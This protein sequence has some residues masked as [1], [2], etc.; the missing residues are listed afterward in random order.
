[1]GDGSFVLTSN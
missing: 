1:H